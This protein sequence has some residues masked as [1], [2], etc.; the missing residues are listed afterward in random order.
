MPEPNPRKEF[1]RLLKPR[2][3][4][5]LGVLRRF[6]EAESPSLEKKA[7]DRCCGLVAEEWRKR[8]ARVE[9][10]ALKHR[11]DIL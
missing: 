5:M 2:L 9:R 3:Q 8:G 11:G 4:D 10:L 1:L 6:V 7:A